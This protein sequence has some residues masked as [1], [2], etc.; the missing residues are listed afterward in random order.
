[1]PITREEVWRI[2]EEYMA[3]DPQRERRPV[4]KVVTYQEILAAGARPPK[5][6]D[7]TGRALLTSWI[8]YLEGVP[9]LLGSS[10]IILVSRDTGQVLYFG[11]ADDEG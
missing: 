2:A 4:T 11:S 6:Y 8:V 5:P 1:M 10:R 7:V 9:A 3:G